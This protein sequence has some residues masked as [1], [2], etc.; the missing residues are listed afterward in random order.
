M[1]ARQG[2]TQTVSFIESPFRTIYYQQFD[3]GVP[4]VVDFVEPSRQGL[5]PV[6]DRL[7][8]PVPLDVQVL[9][10]ILGSLYIY[11]GSFKFLFSRFM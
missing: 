4:E 6:G 10:M 11:L 1:Y 5:G 9:K 2:V 3:E 7:P 8:V